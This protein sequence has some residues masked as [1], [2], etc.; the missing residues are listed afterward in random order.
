MSSCDSPIPGK[1]I[2]LKISIK[3]VTAGSTTTLYTQDILWVTVHSA[4]NAKCRVLNQE[5]YV[6]VLADINT[7]KIL[8]FWQML[9][10]KYLFTGY[11]AKVT[12]ECNIATPK[13]PVIVSFSCCMFVKLRRP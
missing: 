10:R 13:S 7:A 6:A 1:F 12:R 8:A 5:C 2:G 11:L 9:H 4:L 3:P